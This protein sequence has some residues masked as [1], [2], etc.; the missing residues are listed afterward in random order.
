MVKTCGSFPPAGDSLMLSWSWQGRE[1]EGSGGEDE[2]FQG[3]CADQGKDQGHRAL[4]TTGGAGAA[5]TGP[6]L[7][8]PTFPAPCG[9]RTP[10]QKQGPP[11]ARMGS[12]ARPATH[13]SPGSWLSRESPSLRSLHPSCLAPVL[14]LVPYRPCG[15]TSWFSPGQAG[16]E[17]HCHR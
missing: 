10:L 4:Q 1:G 13:H 16:A 11:S 8:A 17:A 15:K 5:G 6:L 3:P 9:R 12:H 14:I 7:P 2:A